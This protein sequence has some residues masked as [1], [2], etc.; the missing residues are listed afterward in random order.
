M[1]E[2]GYEVE[3]CF[4]V[5]FDVGEFWGVAGGKSA[6]GFAG[7]DAFDVQNTGNGLGVVLG[8]DEQH[9]SSQ[10]GE[11]GLYEHAFILLILLKTIT[12]RIR[13]LLIDVRNLKKGL[14]ANIHVIIAS[15]RRRNIDKHPRVGHRHHSIRIGQQ[16]PHVVVPK[17]SGDGACRWASQ[18][19]LLGIGQII[20]VDEILEVGAGVIGASHKQLGVFVSDAVLVVALVEGTIAVLN[21]YFGPACEFALLRVCRQIPPVYG[22]LL[23]QVFTAAEVRFASLVA[24]LDH[25]GDAGAD[26]GTTAVEKDDEFIGVVALVDVEGGRRAIETSGFGVGVV[27]NLFERLLSREDGWE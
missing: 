1:H 16:P 11:N 7:F 2:I 22:D 24:I 14:H 5:D 26:A 8:I 12:D 4:A 13:R 3:I 25:V 17:I 15:L 23:F 18:N 10:W 20:L 6:A 9:V 21:Y 27:D 19:Y